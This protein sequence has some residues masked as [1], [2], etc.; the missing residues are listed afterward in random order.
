MTLKAAIVVIVY[1]LRHADLLSLWRTYTVKAF[2]KRC[3]SVK[4]M[5]K[6]K[7]LKIDKQDHR[8]QKKTQF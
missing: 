1:G 3:F 5:G 8:F 6:K 4:Q 2:S 7:L